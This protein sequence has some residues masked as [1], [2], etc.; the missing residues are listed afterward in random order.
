MRASCCPV[1]PSSAK[2][3]LLIGGTGRIAGIASFWDLS[4]EQKLLAHFGEAG[5]A[6]LLVR[7]IQ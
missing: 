6:V 7:K 1:V 5:A 2:T 3:T 4:R